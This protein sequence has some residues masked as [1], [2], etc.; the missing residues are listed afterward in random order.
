MLREIL[1]AGRR[2]YLISGF[3]NEWQLS[4]QSYLTGR[5]AVEMPLTRQTEE[6]LQPGWSV[7]W[8]PS[9]GAALSCDTFLITEEGPKIVTTLEV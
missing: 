5:S 8:N 7:T 1:L 6:L 2:I 9:A 4:P 3:E